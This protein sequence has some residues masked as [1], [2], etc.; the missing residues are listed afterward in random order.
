MLSKKY[1]LYDHTVNV[2]Y[3]RAKELKNEDVYLVFLH[4]ALGS[5][6][7]W[8]NFP[9]LLCDELGVNGFIIERQGH[10][11]SDPFTEKRTS[12]YL[13]EAAID[14]LPQVMT[15][16]I[17]GGK[18]IVLV[19]HSDGGTIALLHAAQ[20][21]KHILGVVTMAAHV[22]VEKETLE[23]IEPAVEAYESGKLDGLKRFHGEKTDALF[24]AWADTWR[25]PEFETWNIVEDIKGFPR[26]ALII[27]G[28]QDQYGTEKQVGLICSQLPL[29]TPVL[30]DNCK[31]H[32]HLEKTEE[33]VALI[34]SWKASVNLF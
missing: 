10:G 12:R 33:L 1:K 13:H 15:H 29:S 11:A 14:E 34:G 20:F 5:I 32:P 6:G 16:I 8:K 31:H 22:I 27:Q 2:G 24:Y 18:K 28:K 9:K 23:G 7:Q 21:P 25:S 26:P 3:I 30:L 4:E 17:P 19:G